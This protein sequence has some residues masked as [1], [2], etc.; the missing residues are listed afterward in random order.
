MNIPELVTH[1]RPTEDELRLHARIKNFLD[2]NYPC[3]QHPGCC[4]EEEEAWAI[5]DMVKS[6]V[7]EP[8]KET[9]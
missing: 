9:P 7:Y 5:L 1:A 4:G 2:R 3:C 6:A 8:T